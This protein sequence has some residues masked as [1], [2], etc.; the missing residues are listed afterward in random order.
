MYPHCSLYTIN[1]Y[2]I[3]PYTNVDAEFYRYKI[4]CSSL[5]SLFSDDASYDC[6]CNAKEPVCLNMYENINIKD[7][8]T[9]F[10]IVNAYRIKMEAEEQLENEQQ[11]IADADK[12]LETLK[13]CKILEKFKF[14]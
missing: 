4:H 3:G 12:K 8:K 7:H 13:T 2:Q 5:S 14:Q 11:I 6:T 10:N 9:M 1:G